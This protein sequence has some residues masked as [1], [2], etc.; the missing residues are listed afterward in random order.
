MV[1][2]S[3]KVPNINN[4]ISIGTIVGITHFVLYYITITVSVEVFLP[5]LYPSPSLSQAFLMTGISKGIE[6]NDISYLLRIWQVSIFA[7]LCINLSVAG[8]YSYFLLSSVKKRKTIK[9]HI[10]FGFVL[11]VVFFLSLIFFSNHYIASIFAILFLLFI[12]SF[13]IFKKNIVYI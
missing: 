8:S 7:V 13:F 5:L 4:A 10:L 3:N 6:Q 12:I 9:K 11:L 1:L 2:Y